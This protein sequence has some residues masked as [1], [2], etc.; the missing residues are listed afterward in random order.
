MCMGITHLNKRESKPKYQSSEILCKI[1]APVL[2]FSHSLLLSYKI[3]TAVPESCCLYSHH[4][5]A[6]FPVRAGNCCSRVGSSR[7]FIAIQSSS[8]RKVWCI[9]SV[10]S[11]PSRSRCIPGSL[12][13]V[14]I[15]QN[16]PVY[17]APV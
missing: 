1:E 11:R 12:V 6:L 3:P 17:L 13:Y 8:H 2:P 5:G 15:P 14:L 9:D 7:Q 10:G 16:P 4:K